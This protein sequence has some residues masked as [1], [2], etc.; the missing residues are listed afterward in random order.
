VDSQV[1]ERIVGAAVL[2]ALA[3]WII[4]WVLDG[5]DEPV[6]EAES[7]AALTLPPP[8][9]SPPVRTE[10]VEVERRPPP[11]T[12]RAA[13]PPELRPAEA[14]RIE[15]EAVAEVT[16]P[17]PAPVARVSSPEPVRA[18]AAEA[19]P[20]TAPA[21]GEW[22]VQLGSFSE[23]ANANQQARRVSEFGYTARVSEFRSSGGIMYRVRVGGFESRELAEVAASS[24]SA[25]GFPP[26]VFPP[27]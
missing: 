20:V 25:H 24:L 7:G 14:S 13:P 12:P 16:A 26:R 9:A 21:G 8:E 4:P 10:T 15:A 18:P 2:V 19:A 3:V 6:V 23:L 1:K 5:P 11:I 22:T 27:E 17:T